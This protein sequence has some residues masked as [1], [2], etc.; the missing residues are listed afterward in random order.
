MVA[1]QRGA[2]TD[3]DRDFTAA[4]R[5]VVA[6]AG[7]S[8]G[9]AYRR[10]I[11]SVSCPVLLLH[12]SGDRL[13]PVAA[14]VAA[15]RRNPSWSLV[16]LPDVGHV[17]QLEAATETAAAITG[18]LGSAGQPAADA[19]TPGAGRAA[20]RRSRLA[21]HNAA[22]RRDA[23]AARWNEQVAEGGGVCAHRRSPSVQ[24][25]LETCITRGGRA[26]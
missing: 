20:W 11:R 22:T 7:Y 1:R 5:S 25:G 12:G 13:V 3:A 23:S 10:G 17:P 15:A 6:T 18:W 24:S 2:F 16:V 19:A 4:T 26:R 21:G 8:R 14:A 9:Q